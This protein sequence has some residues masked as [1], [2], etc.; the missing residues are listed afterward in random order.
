MLIEQEMAQIGLCQGE[1]RL[2]RK[3]PVKTLFGFRGLILLYSYYSEEHPCIS[4]A[5]IPLQKRLQ[6][7]RCFHGL[8]VIEKTTSSLKSIGCLRWHS[9]CGHHQGDH[10]GIENSR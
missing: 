10:E 9:Q 7:V 8:S 3:C 5:G 2:D 6:R 1:I 4:V